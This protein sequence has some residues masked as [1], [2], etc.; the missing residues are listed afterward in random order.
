[1]VAALPVK[2][3]QVVLDVFTSSD[4]DTAALQLGRSWARLLDGIFD[5]CP[6]G[7]LDDLGNADREGTL[8]VVN[9]L[10]EEDK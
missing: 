5:I 3:R 2:V 4:D 9:E 10:L 1:M 6:L 7:Y 8:K